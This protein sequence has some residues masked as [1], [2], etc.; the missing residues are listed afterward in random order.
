MCISVDGLKLFYKAILDTSPWNVDP[1]TPRMPWSEARYHLEEH[2]GEGAKL[3]FAVMWDDGK[4][5]LLRH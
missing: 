2:G 3:C 1:W 5:S 4:S